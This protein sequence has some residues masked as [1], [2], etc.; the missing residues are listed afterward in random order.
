MKKLLLSSLAL[1][2]VGCSTQSYVPAEDGSIGDGMGGRISKEDQ[3]YVTKYYLDQRLSRLSEIINGTEAP[4]EN[5]KI[6]LEHMKEN[7]NL[8]PLCYCQ[9]SEDSEYNRSRG[10]FPKRYLNKT[11]VVCDT[12]DP[13]QVG[14]IE[15]GDFPYLP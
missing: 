8:S 7:R 9:W 4:M 14:G 13:F 2:L 15:C 11:H 10:T 3:T 1:L 12:C 5:C 6:H